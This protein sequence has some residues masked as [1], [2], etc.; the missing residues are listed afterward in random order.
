MD[1]YRTYYKLYS[2]ASED[3][4]KASKEHWLKIYRESLNSG[5]DDTL[6]THSALTLATIL[7]ADED[8][9]N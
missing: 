1:Y 8:L 5:K 7:L 9:K 4:R 6:T 2:N 3:K